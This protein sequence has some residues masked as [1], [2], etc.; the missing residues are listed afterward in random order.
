MPARWRVGLA[1]AVVL[2]AAALSAAPAWAA[3]TW[4]GTWSSTFGEMQ[5]DADGSGFYPNG[6]ISGGITG[7]QGRTNKGTWRTFQDSFG[8]NYVFNLNESGKAFTGTYDS[9]G[10]CDSPPC[11]WD[12]ACTSGP[13]LQNSA[14]EPERTGPFVTLGDLRG[15]VEVALRQGAWQPATPGMKLRQSDKIHTGFKSGATLTFPDGSTVRMEPMSLILLEK[16]SRADAQG[17]RVRVFLKLGDVKASVSRLRGSHADFEVKTPTTTTSS[18]GTKF[19]VLYTGSSTLVAVTES[20]VDVTARNGRTVV[21]PAGMQTDSTAKRVAEPVKIGHGETRGGL[22]V[23]QAL[24]RLTG[25]LAKKLKACK[26]G[27]TSNRLSPAKRGWNG[28][29]VIVG[30]RQGIDDKPKGTAK[31]RVRGRKVTARNAL[32]RKIRGSCP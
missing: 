3:Y 24:E 20:S 23:T 18:R 14:D 7:D 27:V 22:S 21:V 10:A 25:K 32:A 8:G 12:G 15:K 30:K 19:S 31:F 11:S 9:D 13:C 17:F 2:A 6:F 16:F 5:M 29:L 4:E 1:L 26:F 28:A